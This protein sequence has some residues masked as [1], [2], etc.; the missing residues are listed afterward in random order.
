M[1]FRDR[2]AISLLL[3]VVTGLF[4][5][6]R[7]LS[8]EADKDSVG[9]TRRVL[10]L[11]SNVKELDTFLTVARNIRIPNASV[12]GYRIGSFPL[13]DSTQT[14][15]VFVALGYKCLKL[16]G[17]GWCLLDPAFYFITGRHLRGEDAILKI[18]PP[19]EDISGRSITDVA[20]FKN[21]VLYLSQV[22][23]RKIWNNPSAIGGDAGVRHFFSWLRSV[24]SFA[25]RFL[26]IAACF[27]SKCGPQCRKPSW[28]HRLVYQQR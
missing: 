27:R 8:G 28:K 17:I 18:L 14:K 25:A 21:R 4:V 5:D 19:N 2:V 9:R 23:G 7:F 22:S 13:R 6:E 3:V 26:E 12:D 1:T 20:K 16:S 24:L 11:N 10:H 15:F